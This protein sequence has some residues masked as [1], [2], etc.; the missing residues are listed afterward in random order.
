M[1]II[2]ALR[3]ILWGKCI[4]LWPTDKKSKYRL[5]KE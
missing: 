1:A 5:L 2:A 4:Y 3:P